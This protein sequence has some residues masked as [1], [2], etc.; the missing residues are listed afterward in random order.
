MIS[1]DVSSQGDIRCDDV[2]DEQFEE[3]GDAVM[4]AMIGDDEQHELMDNMMGGEGA[5]S[6][7]S[8]HISVWGSVI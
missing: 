6:L 5:E 8:M 4:Q 7:R 3:L 2:V 1:Q